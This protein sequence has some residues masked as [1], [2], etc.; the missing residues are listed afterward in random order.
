LYLNDE[1]LYEIEITRDDHSE[2]LASTTLLS[3]KEDPVEGVDDTFHS[4]I[5]AG[6]S[7][8][9]KVPVFIHIKSGKIYLL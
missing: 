4:V 9:S 7:D 3:K 5:T 8:K 2:V 1:H 6:N